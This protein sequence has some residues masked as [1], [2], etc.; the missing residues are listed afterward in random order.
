[1][2]ILSSAAQATLTGASTQ[3]MS[4]T[5]TTPA[6]TGGA[7][8]SMGTVT[9]IQLVVIAVFALLMLAVI[10]YGMR[11]RAKHRAAEREERARLDSL[12]DAVPLGEAEPLTS[13]AQEQQ[14]PAPAERGVDPPGRVATD[15]P[16]RV[17]RHDPV[18]SREEP[19]ARAPTSLTQIKGLG[20]K[21]QARLGELGVTRVDQ[22][23][24]LTDDQA[25]ALDAELGAFRGRIARDR[26]VE[27]ARFLAAGDVRGF[28]AVFG[29][30]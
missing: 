14:R 27:Q 15:T 29:R 3:P 6:P 2:Q 4:A 26:W 12:G 11:Q 13:P 9:T 18:E 16:A 21:V 7:L 25:D 19:V 22:L 17:P 10:V 20:P 8:S 30:L 1:M 5:P 24:A 23:A 28:E